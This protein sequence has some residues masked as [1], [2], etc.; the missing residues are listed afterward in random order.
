MARYSGP[1]RQ[2]REGRAAADERRGGRPGGKPLLKRLKNIDY[3]E[4]RDLDF[5]PFFL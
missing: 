5:L 3:P 1:C 4:N 2:I